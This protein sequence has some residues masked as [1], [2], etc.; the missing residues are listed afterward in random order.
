MKK[1]S[2]R[3]KIFKLKSLIS[4]RFIKTFVSNVMHLKNLQNNIKN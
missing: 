4:F 2:K 3:S 1:K